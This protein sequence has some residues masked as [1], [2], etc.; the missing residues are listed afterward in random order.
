MN[1]FILGLGA[2]L[3][4]ALIFFNL[5]QRESARKLREQN[6]VQ[7]QELD[8]LSAENERLSHNHNMSE[9]AQQ[10]RFPDDRFAELLRLRGEIATLRTL[11]NA[12]TL[13]HY[14]ALNDDV[15]LT[16][17]PALWRP[18]SYVRGSELQS[19]TLEIQQDPWLQITLAKHASP[20]NESDYKRERLDRQMLRGDPAELVDERHE[21]WNGREWLVL[22]FRN[23]NFSPPRSEICYFL[24]GD[25]SH[26]T[27]F[28]VGEEAVLS[29]R[30][31]A[32]EAFLNQLRIADPP[33]G[34]TG[35]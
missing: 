24:P 5:T 32:I 8:R 34:R 10:P 11:T 2:I 31:P 20:K 27:L 14:L 12:P 33:I 17:D 7:Q 35:G 9:P 18:L 1:K 21:T 13:V 28:V 29:A 3:I 25:N 6:R 15:S 26:V 30:R 19:T 16:Y 23:A 22:E 4:G